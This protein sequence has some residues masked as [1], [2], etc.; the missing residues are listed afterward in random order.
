MRVRR[1][2]ADRFRWVDVEGVR[3]ASPPLAWALMGHRCSV[4]E[5]VVLGDAIVTD[6]ANDPDRRIPG[7][8]ASLDELRAIAA[9]W[10]RAKGVGALHAALP[11]IRA[12]VES[13]R[14]SDM[15]LLIVDAGMPEPEVQVP[16][17]DPAD[18]RFLGRA[19][20][21]H[22]AARVVEEYEGAGHRAERQWD[23]DIEKYRDFERVGLHVVRATN[24]DF[25]PSPARWL[26]GL[27]AVLAR[28]TPR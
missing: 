1:L 10:R 3:V 15:R 25:V 26:D 9:T 8:L 18:G 22:R 21:M 17:H 6:A 11:R 16:V 23:R 14:E 27:A 7:P 4:H 20:L 5:L 24:R 13:P 2:A 28:R 12:H 19:D